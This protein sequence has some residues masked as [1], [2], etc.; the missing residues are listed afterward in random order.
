MLSDGYDVVKASEDRLITQLKQ[1]GK[2]R[3][4]LKI[5]ISNCTFLKDKHEIKISYNSFCRA[6]GYS[7][8]GKQKSRFFIRPVSSLKPDGGPASLIDITIVKKF[9][10]FAQEYLNGH[11]TQRSI[12]SIDHIRDKCQLLMQEDLEQAPSDTSEK[13]IKTIQD[14]HIPQYKYSFRVLAVDSHK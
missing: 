5:H 13:D 10:L 6:T 11:S 12:D 14:K 1:T 3:L 8:L 7:K 9:K 2:L 4:G